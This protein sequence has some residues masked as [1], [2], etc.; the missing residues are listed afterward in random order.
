M[1]SKMISVN[2]TPCGGARTVNQRRRPQFPVA[3]A[4]RNGFEVSVA[5]LVSFFWAKGLNRSG[6]LSPRT[7]S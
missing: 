2:R 5:H 4:G 3:A 1:I 6:T 7:K